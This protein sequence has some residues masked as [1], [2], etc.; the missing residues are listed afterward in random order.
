MEYVGY[1]TYYNLPGLTAS[2][3]YFNRNAMTCAMTGEKANLGTIVKVR[4][5]VSGRTIK[6]KVNDRG[7]FE[8]GP[9]GRAL[10]PLRPDRDVIIDLTPAAFRAM[11]G[12]LGSGKVRV[13]VSVP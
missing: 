12:S 4:S 1:C 6:V 9:D 3:E 8:R 11:V 5:D 7:P 13:R 2:G 10:R